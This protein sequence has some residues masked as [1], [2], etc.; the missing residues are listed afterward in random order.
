MNLITP[1]HR[2]VCG[3]MT[4]LVVAAALGGSSAHAESWAE[5]QNRLAYEYKM[6]M[7]HPDSETNRQ[8]RSESNS[9]APSGGGTGGVGEAVGAVV[10]VGLICFFVSDCREQFTGE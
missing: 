7:T 5:T 8:R 9:V 4:A 2:A 10:V 1:S 6:E 3:S